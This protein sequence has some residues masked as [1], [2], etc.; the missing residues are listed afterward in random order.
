MLLI[1][2]R[3]ISAVLCRE[4][5]SM[6][7]I[8]LMT[9]CNPLFVFSV[10]VR[11]VFSPEKRERRKVYSSNGSQLASLLCPVLQKE[12]RQA[13]Q[14]VCDRLTKCLTAR[15]NLGMTF[16]TVL[17]VVFFIRTTTIY[18]ARCSPLEASVSCVVRSKQDQWVIASVGS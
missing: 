6:P 13:T 17:I 18:F 10:F 14:T 11:A 16:K 5:R 7:S 9:F 4:T 15:Y 3:A 8:L 2:W 12:A 1:P